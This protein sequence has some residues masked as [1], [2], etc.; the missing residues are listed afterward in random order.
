MKNFFKNIFNPGSKKEP[1]LQEQLNEMMRQRQA[2]ARELERIEEK[3]QAIIVNGVNLTGPNAQINRDN[4]EAACTEA[5]AKQAQFTIIGQQIKQLRQQIEM[6]GMTIPTALDI[7]IDA[8]ERKQI[9]LE[10]QQEQMKEKQ[11]RM[12]D[13]TARQNKLY[14]DWMNDGSDTASEYDRL[15]AEA[16]L[17]EAAKP[18]AEPQPEELSEYDRMVAEARQA[19]EAEKA[20]EAEKTED[21]AEA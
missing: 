14:D 3:K 10:M 19:Q 5:K 4:Y 21:S 12:A 16:M 9:E 18:E 2:L 11:R 15:V 17:K 8:L 1:T 13:L 7:D 20:A 6:E